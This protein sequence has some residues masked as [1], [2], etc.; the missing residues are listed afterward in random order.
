V[1]MNRE[2]WM[3][4]LKKSRPHTGLSSQRCWWCWIS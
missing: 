3:K 1:A 4:P 2:D